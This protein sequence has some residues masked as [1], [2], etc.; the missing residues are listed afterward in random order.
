VTGTVTSQERCPR[1][2]GNIE[3]PYVRR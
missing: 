1:A 3:F 2:I